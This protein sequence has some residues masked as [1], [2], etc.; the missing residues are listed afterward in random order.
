VHLRFFHNLFCLCFEIDTVQLLFIVYWWFVSL[1]WNFTQKYIMF[2]FKLIPTISK[3]NNNFSQFHYICLEKNE[4]WISQISS[5]ID[6]IRRKVKGIYIKYV[7]MVLRG[8]NIFFTFFKV[9][10]IDCNNFENLSLRFRWL[11]HK[12][13]TQSQV[14][15]RDLGMDFFVFIH[16]IVHFIFVTST[17]SHKTVSMQTLL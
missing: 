5:F 11:D 2:G 9:L 3:F 6:S 17:S 16:Y 1:F 15:W 12:P 4:H 7:K 13:D 10:T 8:K 14:W